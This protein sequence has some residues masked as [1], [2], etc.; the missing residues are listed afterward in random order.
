MYD[1]REQI[2]LVVL[3]VTTGNHWLWNIKELGSRSL[4]T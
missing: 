1:N 4:T 2:T 3:V